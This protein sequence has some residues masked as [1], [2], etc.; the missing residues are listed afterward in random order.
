MIKQRFY[1][2][3][4][5]LIGKSEKWGRTK[6]G[7]PFVYTK[8]KNFMKEM[9]VHFATGFPYGGKVDVEIWMSVSTRREHHNVL[10]PIFDAMQASGIIKNDKLIE[11]LILHR[12]KRHKMKELDEVVVVIRDAE[13]DLV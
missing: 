2:P 8:Y 7:F 13:T 12:P 6:K 9:A 3:A 11:E 4:I 10:E 5:K 1:I